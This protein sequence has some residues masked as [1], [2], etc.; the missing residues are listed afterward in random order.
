MVYEKVYF[1]FTSG[2]FKVNEEELEKGAILDKGSAK[3]EI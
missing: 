2:G 3:D 1:W